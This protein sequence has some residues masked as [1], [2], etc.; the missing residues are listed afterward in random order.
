MLWELSVSLNGMNASR[1]R[2]D[3]KKRFD[4]FQDQRSPGDARRELDSRMLNSVN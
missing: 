3:K 1:A 2:K 4:E